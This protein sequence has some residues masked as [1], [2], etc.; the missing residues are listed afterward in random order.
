MHLFCCDQASIPAVAPTDPL[1]DEVVPANVRHRQ[2]QG[3][4]K[5]GDLSWDDA[6]ALAAPTFIRTIKE[7]LH[8][9]AN[10]EERP[11]CLHW[12]HG[13]RRQQ[14][15]QQQRV[16]VSVVIPS[17]ERSATHPTRI[18]TALRQLV[19]PGCNL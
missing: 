5:V 9:Q 7:Q 18:G 15:Q 11:V 14:Q 19:S 4:V 12:R 17:G 16:C 1:W 8:A 6:Q 10:A 3:G 13:S 2:A